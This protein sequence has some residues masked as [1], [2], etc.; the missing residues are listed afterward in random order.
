MSNSGGDSFFSRLP[1]WSRLLLAILTGIFALFLSDN[2]V[3]AGVGWA[4][5]T[6]LAVWLWVDLA[7]KIFKGPFKRPVVSVGVSD[8]RPWMLRIGGVL[9]LLCSVGWTIYWAWLLWQA[10]LPFLS[11]QFEIMALNTL[12]GDAD[13]YELTDMLIWNQE[14]HEDKGVKISFPLQIVPR[15]SGWKQFGKVVAR[16][17]GDGTPLPDQVLWLDF[18]NDSGSTEVV[19][20][21]SELLQASG[22]G[23]NS[24]PPSNA[25]DGQGT[26]FQQ[27]TLTIEIVRAG[28]AQAPWATKQIAVRNAPWQLQSELV[29]RDGHHEVDIALMN[30]GGTGDFWV[31]YH[32]VRLEEEIGSDPGPMTSGTSTVDLQTDPK[33]PVHLEKGELFASTVAMPTDLPSGRYLLEVYALKRQNYVEFVESVDPETGS[34]VPKSTWEDIDTLQTP[35]WFG[36]SPDDRHI[37]LETTGIPVDEQIQ[38]EL[39]RLRDQGVDLGIAMGQLS[40]VTSANG[41]VG[42]RQLFQEGEVY[43]RNDQVYALYGPVLDHYRAWGGI[44]HELLDFPSSPITTVLSSSGAEGMRMECEGDPEWPCV[45]YSSWETVAASWG[46]IAKTYLD[47][48]GGHS[49]WLGFPLADARVYAESVIQLFENGYIVFYYPTIDGETDKSHPPVAI[50]YLGSQG[51]LFDVYA[52]ETWQNTGIEIHTG[53]RVTVVQVGGEW[54][55]WELQDRM[56]DANGDPEW[57]VAPQDL[58]QPTSPIGSLIGRIGESPEGVFSVGRLNTRTSLAGGLLYLAMNDYYTLDNLGAITVQVLVEPAD[59]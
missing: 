59:Q 20:T 54:N 21:L 24:D 47:T 8:F 56:F 35:W 33:P 39:D 52:E 10:A 44:E 31:R 9:L 4:A 46:W 50:P 49:G 28:P 51:T 22:L 27:A 1:N 25:L 55:Y 36:R 45:L 40:E 29:W 30:L 43:V 19:L 38:A 15:Y 2:I 57:D 58:P 37:W 32:V 6:I 23:L 53:D 42:S 3:L 16:V 14:G 7:K 34:T 41:T 11:P 17:S 18:P 26:P 5:A 48:H 12:E 13:V